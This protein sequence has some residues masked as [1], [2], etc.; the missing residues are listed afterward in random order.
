M[1]RRSAAHARNTRDAIVGR[2]VDVASVEGLEGI[3]IG[4]LASD[5]RM[6]KAGVI[7]HFG[8]KET[9]QLAALDGAIEVFRREVWERAAEA[10]PGRGRLEAICDAWVDY[11]TRGTFPGGCFLTAASTEF[12]GR[13]GPVRDAVT[14]TL[15]LW[16]RVLEREAATAIA[17][18][19]LP[20]DADPADVAFAILGAAL[21]LNQA[22]QLHRDAEAPHR[23]RRLMAAAVGR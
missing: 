10:R 13:E 11:L 20:R 16:N 12:D 15:G 2:A 19:D 7:G 8:S 4:R 6:S 14:E 23:A 18:G 22:V 1:P 3:T 5:L 21:A 17:D 9:L